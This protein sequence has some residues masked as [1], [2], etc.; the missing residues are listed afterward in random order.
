MPTKHIT[1]YTEFLMLKK[2]IAQEFLMLKK[3]IAQS[4]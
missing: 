4:F 1:H 2:H 3:H